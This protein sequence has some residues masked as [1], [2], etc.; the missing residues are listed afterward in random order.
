MATAWH[1]LGSKVTLLARASRLLPRMEPFVG[2]FVN[3]G[4]TV[5]AYASAPLR[6]ES[7]HVEFPPDA[8]WVF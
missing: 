5:R 3:N 1:G 4:L 8:V 2:E 6:H 7:Y